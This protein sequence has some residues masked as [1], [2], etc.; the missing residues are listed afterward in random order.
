MTADAIRFWTRAAALTAIAWL[1]LG[2]AV[3]NSMFAGQ[4]PF[5]SDNVAWTFVIAIYVASAVGVLWR[6]R[7]VAATLLV[8]A[9]SYPFMRWVWA[10]V[11]PWIVADAIAIVV[12]SRAFEATVAHHA[13][14]APPSR[15]GLRVKRVVRFAGLT[16]AIGLMWIMGTMPS[17]QVVSGDQLPRTY[18]RALDD[19]RLLQV[20]E[21][22]RFMA[23][24]ALFRVSAAMYVLTDRRL[25]LHNTSWAEATLQIE[26]SRIADVLFLPAELNLDFSYVTVVLDDD[27]VLS[28]GLSAMGGLDARFHD[29][30]VAS[31]REHAPTSVGGAHA[32]RIEPNG[33][34]EPAALVE[35]RRRMP[36]VR[37]LE[38]NS[39]L[40]ENH[41][42]LQLQDAGYWPPWIFRDLDRDGRVD[43][44]A[45][46][47]RPSPDGIEFAAVALHGDAPGEARWIVPFQSQPLY[48]VSGKRGTDAVNVLFCVFCDWDLWFRWNGGHYEDDLYAVG[49]TV[50][51]ADGNREAP[52]PLFRSQIAETADHLTT[53]PGCTLG[54][55]RRVSGYPGARW[56]EV[57]VPN[58]TGRA[59]I[60]AKFTD[61]NTCMG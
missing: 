10:D 32:L 13:A 26:F 36:G 31:W 53:V 28:F 17:A 61:V 33:M 24:D 19:S 48:G 56:Y 3:P 2:L 52:T 45:V 57:E 54:V 20:D 60:P 15:L 12:Y 35:L 46:L 51:I 11:W 49:E 5:P 21:R 55:V 9:G 47:V 38:P 1:V 41:T 34:N 23:S 50:V 7:V 44:A 4:E 39:D 30:L 59:W 27:S 8:G 25:L 37:L 22:V 16:L 43:L 29:A 6:S 58:V 14:K 18:R 40:D 42:T